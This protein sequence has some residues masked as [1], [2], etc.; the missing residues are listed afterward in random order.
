MLATLLVTVVAFA[1]LMGAMSIGVILRGK[2]LRGSC[3]GDPNS[4]HCGCSPEKRATCRKE[5]AP[6]DPD[7]EVDDVFSLRPV[8]EE[9][10]APPGERRLIQLRTG[11]E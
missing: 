2:R 6:S 7:E 3:G 8:T 5:H 4:V 1:L 9:T 11:R 10:L